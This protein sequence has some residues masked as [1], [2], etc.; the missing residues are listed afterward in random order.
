M[1]RE[2]LPTR[3]CARAITGTKAGLTSHVGRSESHESC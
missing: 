3:R 1:R 2:R